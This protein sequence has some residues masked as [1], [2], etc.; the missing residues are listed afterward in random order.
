MSSTGMDMAR[1]MIAHLQFGQYDSV[2]ILA[3]S[4]ARYMATTQF[5]T[6]PAVPG[7]AVGFFEESRD[8]YRMIGHGGDLSRFHSHM[9]LL[10]DEGVGLFISINSAGSGGGL[11]GIRETVIDAFMHRYFPRTT[12]LEPV[13]A[14]AREIAPRVVGSY[15]LSRRGET[16]L[17][18]VAGLALPLAI[19]ANPDGSIQIPLLTGTNGQPIRWYPIEPTVYRNTEGNMRLGFVTDSTTGEVTRVGFIGGHELHK[20]GLA[21][22]VRFNYW[23]IGLCLA[24]M[25]ATL[26]LW[27]VAAIIRRRTG[28]PLPDDGLSR[29]FR[30]ITRLAVVVALSMVFGFAG[31]FS[32]A[33]DGGLRLNSGIDP[34][35][36]VFQLLG[37]LTLIGTVACVVAAGISLLR[38]SNR[39]SQLKYVALALACV[40]FS[41]FILHW[42]ILTSNLDF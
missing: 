29:R 11:F 26:V 21:D 19:E 13:L 17:Y 2:R 9:T 18:R 38:G 15:T 25:I 35:L 23:V 42:N 39:L 27:P 34:V 36:R 1:Y 3:D 20:V 4:T 22:S 14:N 33:M 24:V 6:H 16:T 32:M 40:G 41:W 30:G 10:L 28:Q 5:R 37:V 8:G 31:F 7:M 12:P